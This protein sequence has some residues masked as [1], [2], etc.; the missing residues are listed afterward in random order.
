MSP[1]WVCAVF[2]CGCTGAM[3]SPGGD[4]RRE[5]PFSPITPGAPAADLDLTS[6][7]LYGGEGGVPSPARCPPGKCLCAQPSHRA[8]LGS[9]YQATA[10]KARGLLPGTRCAE[11][12]GLRE[13][14]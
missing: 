2:S 14:E 6:W 3:G 9:L 11:S 7:L 4:V 12:P 1:G 10:Q 13:G 8:G 5:V